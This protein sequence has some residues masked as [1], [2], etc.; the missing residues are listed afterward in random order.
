[1][2]NEK[3]TVSF[4]WMKSKIAIDSQESTTRVVDI[5]QHLNDNIIISPDISLVDRHA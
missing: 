4:L 5:M 2:D 1:M 3:F